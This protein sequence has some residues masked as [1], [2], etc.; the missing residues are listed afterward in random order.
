MKQD[1]PIILEN[2]FVLKFPLNILYG[3]KN[4]LENFLVL[5]YVEIIMW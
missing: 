1:G 5:F 2:S 4:S 3:F